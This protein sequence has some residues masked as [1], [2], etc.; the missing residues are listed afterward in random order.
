MKQ[1][2]FLTSALAVVLLSVC[3]WTFESASARDESKKANDGQVK[4]SS[5]CI[6]LVE[7]KTEAEKCP[8]TGEASFVKFRVTCDTPV[9]VRLYSERRRS[10][11]SSSD[12]SNRKRGDEITDFQ[13][14]PKA[15]FRVVTRPVGSTE[16]WPE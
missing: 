6:E 2:S 13:C 10:G 5:K 12:Y 15:R 1:Q 8:K 14:F 3:V 4:I 11:W 16:K 9:D 7:V